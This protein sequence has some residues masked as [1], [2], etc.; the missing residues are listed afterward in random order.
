MKR[1]LLLLLCLLPCVAQATRLANCDT[2]PYEVTI[3]NG[4][5][6]RQVTLSPGSGAIEEY[7]PTVSFRVKG[8]APVTVTEPY[9]EYCIWKGR[10]TVQTRNTSDSGGSGRLR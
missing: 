9:D 10:I 3:V 4:G 6:T 1:I 5:Q 8:H 2:Q 7:G